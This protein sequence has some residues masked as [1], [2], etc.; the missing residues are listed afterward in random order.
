M[1]LA[2]APSADVVIAG[3]GAAGLHLA[4][5]LSRAGAFAGRRVLLIER[6]SRTGASGAFVNDRTWCFWER[7]EN[8]L[9]HLVFWR[10]ANL[11]FKSPRWSGRL[12]LGG[13]VYK[14]IRGTDFHAAMRADLAGFPEL[15][16]WQGDIT[17]VLDAPEGG[18]E[19]RL[20]DGRVARGQWVFNSTPIG[21]GPAPG[22]N[23]R[24]IQHFLGWVVRTAED[25]F[26]PGAAT[27]MDFR[28]PQGGDTRFVYVLPFDSRTALVEHTVFST[29]PLDRAEYVAAIESYLR[30]QL[31]IGT[32][33]IEHEEYGEIPMTD[34][35]F[36]GQSAGG[37]VVNIGTVGGATKPST[38]YTFKRI[39]AQSAR[40][41]ANLAAGR[42]PLAGRGHEPR[43]F[44]WYDRVLLNV[45]ARGRRSGADVF[46]DLFSRL[47]AGLVFDFLDGRTHLGQDLRVLAN[48][49]KA[50]FLAAALDTAARALGRRPAWH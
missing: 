2:D 43:R 49:A 5:S 44:G 45:L 50:P 31:G 25:C 34:A 18:G 29:R 6:E 12:A 21:A 32:Y 28:T 27:L 42:A 33:W 19:A 11:D 20:R 13:H 41:A 1:T 26:D 10:W 3:A 40:I 15:E 7:A 38:G 22:P 48:A 36:P 46:T 8:P 16:W 14:M 37:G 9:E 17:A 24:L 47:P 23:I 35:S 30:D 39:Q 4:W